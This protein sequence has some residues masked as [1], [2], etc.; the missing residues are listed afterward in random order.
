MTLA[1]A[2]AFRMDYWVRGRLFTASARWEDVHIYALRECLGFGSLVIC[3]YDLL[4]GHR[5]RRS[6]EGM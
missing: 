6:D 4:E 5:P 1:K 2:G 3:P